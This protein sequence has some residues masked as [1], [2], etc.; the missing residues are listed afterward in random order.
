M[1]STINFSILLLS[2]EAEITN[3]GVLSCSVTSVTLTSTPSP[4]S[5]IWKILP[6]QQ[7]VGTG[8]S[9]TVTQP[10]TYVLTVTASAGGNLC[11]DTDTI[12]VTGNTTLPTVSA[13]GGAIGC[14]GAPTLVNAITNASGPTF[15]WTGPNSF[16]SSQQNPSVTQPGSYVVVV[17]DGT[18]GCTNSATATVTG[19]TTP[20]VVNA[21]GATLSCSVTSIQINSSS[22]VPQCY[23]CLDRPQRFYV[24]PTKSDGYSQW[25]LYSSGDQPSQQLYQYRYSNGQLG[26]YAAKLCSD[27]EQPHQLPRPDSDIKCNPG[28]GSDLPVERPEQFHVYRTEPAG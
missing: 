5:K 28:F 15:A 7:V 13:T 23:I 11:V 1:T 26:Q 12:M 19:N 16:T 17:T 6:S 2:P 4:G 9:I 14:G 20:P 8:N 27:G 3:G 25:P 18:T 24:Q 21:T 10:G 22:N